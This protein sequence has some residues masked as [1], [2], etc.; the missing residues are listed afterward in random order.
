MKFISIFTSLLLA[1]SAFGGADPIVRN[2]ITTN[3]APTN[4]Q[5]TRVLIGAAGLPD[6]NLWSG[7]N[8]FSGGLTN[9]GDALLAGSSTN[10]GLA[11]SNGLPTVFDAIAVIRLTSG[12]WG[13]SVNGAAAL[14]TGLRQWAEMYS[15]AYYL[16][17]TN[18]ASL[19]TTTNDMAAAQTLVVTKSGSDSTGT[20]GRLDKPF[21]T[22]GA[23]K[24]A[25]SAGDS[26]VVYPGVYDEHNL[27]KAGVNY[28]GIG[29]P[30]ISNS[31]ANADSTAYGIFDDRPVGATT[32]VINGFD[33]WWSSGTNFTVNTN[34]C[35]YTI[36]AVNA[37]GAFVITNAASTI[38]ARFG[39]VQVS[40]WNSVQF[41]FYFANSTNTYIEFDR[42]SD[43]LRAIT[44]T[45]NNGVCGPLTATSL[46]G[47][48]YWELGD[49]YFKGRTIDDL[50]LYAVDAYGGTNTQTANLWLDCENIYS[51]V[52]AVGF[53]SPNWR[54]WVRTMEA[55]IKA[56][57]GN[58]PFEY[59]G[60]G[61]HYV[62][63]QK[64]ESLGSTYP[65]F[66]ILSNNAVGGL[67]LWVQ[68]EKISGA[69]GWID[70]AAG[71]NLFQVQQLEQ[72]TGSTGNAGIINRAGST[73]KVSAQLASVTNGSLTSALGGTS[74][75][76]LN[77]DGSWLTN[78]NATQLLSGTIPDARFPA[79]LPA[80]SGANLTSLNASAL[81]SGTVPVGLLPSNYTNIA[82]TLT[83][84]TRPL[85]LS[86]TAS[87]YYGDGSHLT[88]I[89]SGT[90]FAN[91]L[92]TN[93]ATAHR[94]QSSGSSP[95]ILTNLPATTT[96]AV[97]DASSTDTRGIIRW[98][99]SA[100][101]VTNQ[102]YFR[103]SFNVADP[104]TNYHVA[105]QPLSVVTLVSGT[106]RFFA[107]NFL[108]T[109]FEIWSG[110]TAPGTSADYII[111]YS[112]IR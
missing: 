106:P 92:A 24:T 64:I 74:V 16:N 40:G 111:G 8:R 36:G 109:S 6:T 84:D 107:T 20:R 105:L 100:S 57:P 58:I 27:L 96:T 55:K 43:P 61:K 26:I 32:N 99:S 17:G 95:T 25:A 21:L 29:Q 13:P 15:Q 86:N 71:T 63:A 3:S 1:V 9:I 75:I 98:T 38:T 81:A 18:I 60:S 85:L 2:Y 73:L 88:G 83:N 87:V 72:T 30:V 103:I 34:T 93:T 31:L 97:L 70:A 56:S 67:N 49:A 42:V 52:Y 39:Q 19:F 5:T 80:L 54:T 10:S 68:A 104:S 110:N 51:K 65:A 23:A 77:E 48:I 79:T 102:Q 112:V 62:S 69:G 47:G 90:N 59:H 78:L 41:A 50:S 35:A 76:A 66:L 108:T 28:Y 53:G 45:T 44:L 94:F 91:I 33:L 12:V 82:N 101:Q 7:P 22:I 37:L 11:V 14:G 89:T 4:A 46:S